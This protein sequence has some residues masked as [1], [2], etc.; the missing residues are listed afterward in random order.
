[1]AGFM[2]GI[3]INYDSQPHGERGYA[4]PGGWPHAHSHT[5]PLIPEGGKRVFV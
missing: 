5:L 1:M 4:P 2:V 3:N